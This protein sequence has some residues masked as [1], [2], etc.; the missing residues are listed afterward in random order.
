MTWIGW[1]VALSSLSLV[2]RLT[3]RWWNRVERIPPADQRPPPEPWP[4]DEPED[5]DADWPQQASDFLAEP[6][7]REGT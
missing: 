7:D 4:E 3:V 2:L 6:D 5:P 1:V